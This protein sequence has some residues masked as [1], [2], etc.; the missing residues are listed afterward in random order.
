MSPKRVSGCLRAR[1][2][3]V[4]VAGG[5]LIVEAFL[6]CQV[7]I[8]A[9][10]LLFRAPP[11]ANLRRGAAKVRP[12]CDGGVL[13]G[14]FSVTAYAR[15][16]VQHFVPFAKICVCASASCHA[17]VPSDDLVPRVCRRGCEGW[18]IVCP[19]GARMLAD[20]G[21][22]NACAWRARTEHFTQCR[23]QIVSSGQL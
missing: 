12:G 16:R 7:F 18:K 10:C 20:W 22:G 14:T 13:L 15:L 11:S 6:T 17:C 4:A 21:L 3:Q 23:V 2:L 5:L 8:A 19:G 9:V 1:G